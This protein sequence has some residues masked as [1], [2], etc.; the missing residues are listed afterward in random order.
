MRFYSVLLVFLVYTF[1]Q[2]SKFF[3]FKL[4]GEGKL[5]IFP[6]LNFSMLLNKGITFGMLSDLKYSNIFFA[7]GSS[8]IVG[9]LFFWLYNTKIKHEI[10]SL[11][12][13]IGGALG[14]ITDRALYEGVVD[15][16]EFH[17]EEHYFP[18]FNLA[19]SAVFLGV[20]I[21]LYFS[22]NWKKKETSN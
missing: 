6:F 22:V 4:L 8:L 5:E 7:I 14:N 19:D 16:L 10:L 1:D 18:T 12:L 3:A 2:I 11:S 17:Y 15:F 13:I 21:L 20:C 9:Y